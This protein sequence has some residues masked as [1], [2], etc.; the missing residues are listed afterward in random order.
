MLDGRKSFMELVG[1][2]INDK[3]LK[4]EEYEFSSNA[5]D[6]RLTVLSP[7][8]ERFTLGVVTKWGGAS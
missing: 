1:I 7:P 5:E 6:T 4:P 3:A 8:T 2:F